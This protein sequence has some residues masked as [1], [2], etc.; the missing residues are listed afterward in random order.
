[1]QEGSPSLNFLPG[2]DISTATLNWKLKLGSVDAASL[3]DL[4]H[5]LPVSEAGENVCKAA[6]EL[7]PRESLDPPEGPH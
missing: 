6:V 3:L 4:T 7:S 1:M 2:V 5:Q